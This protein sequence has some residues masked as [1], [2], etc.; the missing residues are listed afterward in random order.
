MVGHPAYFSFG[1]QLNPRH[2]S[3]LT[4]TF[5]AQNAS[6]RRFYLGHDTMK[7]DK[8]RIVNDP[9][10]RLSEESPTY[11][12]QKSNMSNKSPICLRLVPQS[13]L[14]PWNASA[15]RIRDA[16]LDPQSPPGVPE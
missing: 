12:H 14:C 16:Y 9:A 13:R 6:S 1:S 7:S 10:S 15:H 11:E 8:G 4:S 2:R 3:S 5:Q